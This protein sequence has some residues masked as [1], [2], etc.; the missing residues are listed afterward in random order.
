MIPASKYPVHV[1][2]VGARG[3]SGV[4]NAERGKDLCE[5]NE[6]MPLADLSAYRP[7]CGLGRDG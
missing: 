2:R 5:M 7:R 3:A 4:T 1:S 6:T